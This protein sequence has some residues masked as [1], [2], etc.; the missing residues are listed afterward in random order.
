MKHNTW[1]SNKASTVTHKET[2]SECPALLVVARV[3]DNK[4]VVV[5][6]VVVTVDKE[7]IGVAVEVNKV[8]DVGATSGLIDFEHVPTLPAP[9]TATSSIS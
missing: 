5:L 7:V 9:S 4:V 1:K 2:Y 3:E 8:L 6:F